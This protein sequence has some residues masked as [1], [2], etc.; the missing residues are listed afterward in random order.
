MYPTP[1][2]HL[3]QHIPD[4][5]HNSKFHWRSIMEITRPSQTKVGRSHVNTIVLVFLHIKWLF[6]V[7]MFYLLQ[8]SLWSR[9]LPLMDWKT[10]QLLCPSGLREPQLPEPAW[11]D[12]HCPLHHL[13]PLPKLN[14][15]PPTGKWLPNPFSGAEKSTVAAGYGPLSNIC[16]ENLLP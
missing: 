11:T 10:L 15:V 13:M 8:E 3:Y 4:W 9:N 16:S 12:A 1:R 6:D 2:T 7:S 14:T 5:S